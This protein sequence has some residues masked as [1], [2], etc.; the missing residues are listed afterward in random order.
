MQENT[1]TCT[2]ITKLS[3]NEQIDDNTNYFSK[4]IKKIIL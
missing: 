2:N 3:E 1:W 4:F